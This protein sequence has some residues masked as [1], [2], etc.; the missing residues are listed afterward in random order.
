MLRV[1][2]TKAFLIELPQE[3]HDY[4]HLSTSLL[5]PHYLILIDN[6]GMRLFHIIIFT[7][8]RECVERL[9]VHSDL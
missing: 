9:Y 4:K 8:F 5:L 6:T 1:Q 7:L 3:K 2:V